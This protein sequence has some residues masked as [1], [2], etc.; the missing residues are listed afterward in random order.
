MGVG[1]GT[2]EVEQD[3]EGIRTMKV[4]GATMAWLLGKVAGSP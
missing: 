2:G 3:E 1:R 4:L